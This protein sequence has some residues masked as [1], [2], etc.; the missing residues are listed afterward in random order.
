MTDM[1]KLAVAAHLQVLLRRRLNRVTDVEWMTVNR[2][3]ALEVV[4]LCRSTPHDD[5]HH[6]A[7]R[8]EAIYRRPVNAQ[9]VLV[10]PPMPVT[11]KAAAPKR[12]V[13]SLR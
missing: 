12:Y 11:P 2:D 4:R 5:L 6:W 1:D 7:D 10:S 8:L 3:Y 13:A 9:P